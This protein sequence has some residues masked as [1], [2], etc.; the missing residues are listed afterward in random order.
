MY[1]DRCHFRHEFRSFAKIHRHFYTAHYAALRV[2]AHEI[3][4]ESKA[5]PDGDDM[6]LNFNKEIGIEV[7]D[8]VFKTFLP[9]EALSLCGQVLRLGCFTAVA[10]EECIVRN[11]SSETDSTSNK[12][13]MN[14]SKDSDDLDIDAIL[15][16]SFAY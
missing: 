9:K 6:D 4:A 3:L 1:G 10:T 12:S 11:A 15:D 5:M 7:E 14:Q 13:L 2:T 8:P 16:E